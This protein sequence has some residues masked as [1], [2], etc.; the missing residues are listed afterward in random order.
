MI[1]DR[2]EPGC[3]AGRLRLALAPGFP[4]GQG[5]ANV[6]NVV[7]SLDPEW[8]TMLWQVITRHGFSG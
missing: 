4:G 6:G 3:A 7:A 2:C 5:I 1:L 8:G